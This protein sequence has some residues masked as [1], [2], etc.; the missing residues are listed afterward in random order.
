MLD[1]PKHRGLRQ[2][3]VDDLR[4]KGILDE[5]VL[6]A[7]NEVPRHF[8]MDSAFEHHAYEDKAFPISCNQT[9]SQP[10]TVAYQSQLLQISKGV[11][12]LEIGTGSGYQAS[13]LYKMGAKV[14]TLERHQGL[15]KYSKKIF[16]QLNYKL[17]YQALGDGFKGLSSFMPFDRII[18]TAA[19]D[20]APK[21][22]LNQLNIGGVAIMPIGKN[23]QTMT[24]FIRLSE[25][26]FEKHSFGMFNFVPMLKNTENS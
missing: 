11:K 21:S 17:K 2:K 12:V 18:V 4:K 9:I 13:V 22:L 24:S 23:S 8:F 1:L 14:Y 5:N 15:V 19:L 6:K 26:E 3:L 20:K 16:K 7:I 25:N 10:Y